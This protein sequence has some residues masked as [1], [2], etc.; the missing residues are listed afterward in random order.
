MGS[1]FVAVVF[2]G[3]RPRLQRRDRDGLSPSSLFFR[4]ITNRPDTRV[5]WQSNALALFVKSRELRVCGKQLRL[6]CSGQDR[7]SCLIVL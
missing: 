2:V 4:Q 1:S 3:L 7:Y 5:G 6:A